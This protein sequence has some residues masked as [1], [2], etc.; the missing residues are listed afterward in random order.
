MGH[1]VSKAADNAVKKSTPTKVDQITSESRLRSIRL[2]TEA[3][4]FV[5]GDDVRW[6]LGQYDE[7]VVRHE[8]AQVLIKTSPVVAQVLQSLPTGETV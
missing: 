2:N 4:L 6:L 3:G 5:K 8:A 7:M 1:S